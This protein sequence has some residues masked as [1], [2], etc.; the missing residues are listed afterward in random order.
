[1]NAIQGARPRRGGLDQKTALR[2]IERSVPDL[3]RASDISGLAHARAEALSLAMESTGRR[4]KK[5]QRVAQ[6]AWVAMEGLRQKGVETATERATREIREA[7]EAGWSARETKRRL[8]ERFIALLHLML[9]DGSTPDQSIAIL[10]Q[11]MLVDEDGFLRVEI[12]PTFES[13]A[14]LLVGGYEQSVQV[15]LELNATTPPRNRAE[16]ERLLKEVAVDLMTAGAEV[17]G[18][19]A[20]AVPLIAYALFAERL[21]VAPAVTSAVAVERVNNLLLKIAD[22]VSAMPITKRPLF[23]VLFKMAVLV[24]AAQE[25]AA[26]L[27]LKSLSVS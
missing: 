3:Q 14:P 26:R 21:P 7:Q 19:N 11:L 17:R 1:V 6:N 16:I 4:R 13:W 18:L 5:A 12:Q 24:G 2:L 15:F 9:N 10:R 23:I 27:S 22:D 20:D 25:Y 8:S